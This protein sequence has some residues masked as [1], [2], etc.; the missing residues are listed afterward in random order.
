MHALGRC[1]PATDWAYA[2][3]RLP[4]APTPCC[5]Y[6]PTRFDD[7]KQLDLPLVVIDC[8]KA[9]RPVKMDAKAFFELYRK[10]GH[11]LQEAGA[12]QLLTVWRATDDAPECM[13]VCVRPWHV[14]RVR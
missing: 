6:D 12:G 7:E 11:V 14:R 9:L 1:Y 2:L 13:H 5:R 4:R 3:T 10:V 8:A